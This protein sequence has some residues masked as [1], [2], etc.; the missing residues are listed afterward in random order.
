LVSLGVSMQ[1]RGRYVEDMWSDSDSSG[2]RMV[3][4]WRSRSPPRS[5]PH[6][7]SGLRGAWSME[8]TARTC[9]MQH[10]PCSTHHAACGAQCAVSSMGNAAHCL[11]EAVC[12]GHG[13][14]GDSRPYAIGQVSAASGARWDGVR[15]CANG[16]RGHRQSMHDEAGRGRARQGEAGRGSTRGPRERYG[17]SRRSEPTVAW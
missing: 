7:T 2:T 8:H 13:E 12:S 17:I 5:S 10:V 14:S 9:I 6:E 15:G 16:R 3:I 4:F 11:R 1:E